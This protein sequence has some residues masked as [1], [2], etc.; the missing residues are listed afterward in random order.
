MFQNSI[1]FLRLKCG[2]SALNCSET[3]VRCRQTQN[4]T[5]MRLSTDVKKLEN[6]QNCIKTRQQCLS[7]L[8]VSHFGP[9]LYRHVNTPKWKKCFAAIA[10]ELTRAIFS[11]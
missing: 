10:L 4:F 11:H 1:M 7:S 9:F 5:K 6:L 3:Q 2:G 8:T